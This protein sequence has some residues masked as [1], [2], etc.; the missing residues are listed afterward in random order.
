MMRTILRWFPLS[1]ILLIPLGACDDEELTGPGDGKTYLS[2]F[3]TDQPG[4]VD[5][6]WVEILQVSLHGGDEGHLDLLDEP[7]ELILLTD[8]VGTVQPLVENTEVDA[9]TYT[10]LRLLVG[11][12]V[13]LSTEPKL[14]VKGNPD[15]SSLDFTNL[16]L[17]VDPEELDQGTLQCPSCSQSGLKIKIPGADVELGE[18]ATALVVDFDVAQSFGHKAGNSGKWIMH[19]VI[20]GTVVEDADGDGSVSDELGTAAAIQGSVALDETNPP[21]IPECGGSARSSR[22][23]GSVRADIPLPASSFYRPDRRCT[24]SAFPYSRRSIRRRSL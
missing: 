8:L 10:Q 1:L 9:S 22:P 2:V 14:Y 19:P 18:G 20:H 7:T 23:T 5:A 16:D 3:L 4:E 15:L 24:S 21:T 13:L 6:V 12:A 17:S 11:E